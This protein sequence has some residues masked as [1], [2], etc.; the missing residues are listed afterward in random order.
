MADLR[1]STSLT[2][3]SLTSSTSLSSG[4]GS[5]FTASPFT[6]SPFTASPFTAEFNE[7]LKSADTPLIDAVRWWESAVGPDALNINKELEIELSSAELAAYEL[8]LHG[9][10]EASFNAPP[11]TD[12]YDLSARSQQNC[13][14]TLKQARAALQAQASAQTSSMSS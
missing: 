11:V 12:E 6:A 1:T 14:T 8:C 13:W 10:L 3:T 2:S 5:P 7:R 9:D 4:K